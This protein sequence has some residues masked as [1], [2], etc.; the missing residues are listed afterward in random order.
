MAGQTTLTRFMVVRIH[1]RQ[2][3][4]ESICMDLKPYKITALPFQQSDVE[5]EFTE[6]A[7]SDE[8]ALRNFEKRYPTYRVKEVKEA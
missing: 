7:I 8:Q 6:Y 3:T 5:A 4:S 1:P 2:P